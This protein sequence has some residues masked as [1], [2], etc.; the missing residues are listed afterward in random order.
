M[1]TA[2]FSAKKTPF[3]EKYRTNGAKVID[4]SGWVLPLEFSGTLK[5]AKATRRN[6]TLFDVSHMGVIRISGKKCREYLEQ[7]T[8]N[9]VFNLSNYQLQYNLLVNEKGMI[10]D[11][12][13]VYNLDNEFLCIVNAS[14]KDKVLDWFDV[15]KSKEVDLFDE[16]EITAILSLQGPQAVQLLMQMCKDTT[17]FDLFYMHARGVEVAGVP[18]LISR[19]GYTGEDGFE[20][21]CEIS[22]A[23]R[24]WDC[25]IDS[26]KRFSLI[27]AGLGAR[28]IL[29]V[30]AG[31]P[32]YGNDIDETINP[33]E[34]GLQWAVKY[35]DKDFLGKSSIV[36][37]LK[38]GI[39]RKRI[40]FILDGRGVPRKGYSVRSED[41]ELIGKVT[42]G[43]YSPNLD[44]FI[45]M[46]YVSY[47]FKER[48]TAVTIE[49]R[50]SLYPARI[51][52]FPFVPINVKK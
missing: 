2:I 22:L 45:G 29:R 24:V 47:P 40:G 1:R 37:I 15:H 7:L 30:E 42:S 25:F 12:L 18:C 35:K 19:N 50:N 10:L 8:T 5:E 34:A 43:V 28:D 31:Y 46:A 33:L 49:I 20:I 17:I 3:Y 27:L 26:G 39:Q 41:G 23:S 13:I 51:S 16:T 38:N 11:D 32:L 52:S 14:N 4:F 36:D 6:C 9:T 48:T 21:Y 44:K